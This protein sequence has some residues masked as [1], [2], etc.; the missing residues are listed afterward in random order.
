MLLTVHRRLCDNTGNDQPFGG[1][2][3]LAVGD[4][5][6]LPPVAQKSVFS[7]PSDEMA[8]IY[9]TLWE[10]FQICELVKIVRQ[11]ND[12][13]FASLLNRIRSGTY[14]DDDMILLRERVIQNNDENYPHDATHIFA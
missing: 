12:V 1:V 2:S 8:A 10:H 14:T 9:G 11:K 13:T 7:P 3:V 5:L 6:Q 4:L